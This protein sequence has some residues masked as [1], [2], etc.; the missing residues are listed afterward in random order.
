MRKAE[1]LV[2]A[3]LVLLSAL[4]IAESARLGIGWSDIGPG[5]G[6]VPF[7]FAA[8]VAAASLG[9][10]SQ[11]MRS[12]KVAR[13][14]FFPSRAALFFWLKVLLPM[15]AAVVLVRYLGIYVVAA[16]YLA[17]FGAWIGR[18]RWFVVMGTSLLLPLLMYFS[19]EQFFKLPLPKSLF[20]GS[21]L[22]F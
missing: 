3:A 12:F 21:V 10:L 1:F 9:L 22:P 7:W 17:L 16:I 20:Y 11:E 14:P 4:L 15:V 19:F 6:F 18:H 2:A 13:D 8:A 5:S